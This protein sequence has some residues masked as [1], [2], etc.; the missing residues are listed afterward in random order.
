MK[1]LKKAGK[2]EESWFKKIEQRVAIVE[3][4]LKNQRSLGSAAK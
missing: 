4:Q 1:Y 2:M 3:R